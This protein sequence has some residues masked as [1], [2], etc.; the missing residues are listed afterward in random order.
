MSSEKLVKI[1][2]CLTDK[3]GKIL[4]PY[5]PNAIDYINL[6]PLDNKEQKQVQLPSGALRDTDRLIVAIKGYIALFIG[7][8]RI[9]EPIPFKTKKYFYLY[10][11]KGTNLSFRV[12][13][14]KCG[15]TSIYTQNNSLTKLKI[16][17]NLATLVHSEAIVNLVIPVMETIPA[18]TKKEFKI[19]PECINVSKI[20]DQ[21]L[22]SNEIEII[23]QEE[24]LKASVYQYNTFSDGFKKIYTSED[25]LIQYGNQGILD[26]SQVSFFNLY[27][28]GIL[29]PKVSYNLAKGLLELNTTDA[30]PMNAP[31]TLV[32][33]TLKN[34]KGTIIPAETYQYN[35]IS[36]GV[37]REYSD[38]DE[39]KIYGDQG[40]IDPQ[41]VSMV[42][43]YVNGVL[44][45]KVNYKV[46]KGLLTFLTTDL[47]PQGVPII[48]E[49][50]TLKEAKGETI[51]AKSYTYHT[52]AHEKNTYTDQDELKIYGD[53]GILDPQNVSYYNLFVNAV[54]QPHIN[55]SVEK[56]LLTLQTEDMP[57]IG[58]PIS[59]QFIR[60]TINS[61]ES[62]RIYYK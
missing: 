2:C 51:K 29:Q 25:E 37:K 27:I 62:S 10:S 41:E 7:D 61:N 47:P 18:D 9:S 20:F 43:L 12:C 53:K 44:Q 38:L 5:Q 59:L 6:T 11:P 35:A 16:K 40:I 30:P 4:D 52:Q 33:F 39:L 32:F 19:K 21:C 55:Y 8:Q 23:Y 49:F 36:D 13:N 45:P 22:F 15:I 34:R 54:S 24:F 14:F 57:L 28:N 60:V 58:A 1:N 48:I 31:I 46:E 56:G 42:N 26:P 3:N 50:I 17:V